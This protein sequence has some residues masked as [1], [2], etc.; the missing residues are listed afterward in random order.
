FAITTS[1]KWAI[2]SPVDSGNVSRQE[3]TILVT[4]SSSIV[5]SRRSRSPTRATLADD[6][7]PASFFLPKE[8]V[9]GSSTVEGVPASTVTG[10]AGATVEG[11]LS[12]TVEGDLASTVEGKLDSTLR[13]KNT[14]LPVRTTW[15]L[16]AARWTAMAAE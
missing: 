1:A 9:E 6:V 3:A 12:S 14:P 11:D 8:V 5:S 15:V 13:A 10:E 2:S 16:P 4:A 7:P